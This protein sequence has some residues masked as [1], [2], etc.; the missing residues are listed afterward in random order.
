MAKTNRPPIVTVLGHVDHGKTT[1]LDAIRKTNVQAQE[2]NGITQHISAYQ[3]KI[4][5]Q[6]ITFID[7]PGHQAFVNLR[8][9]GGHLADIAI[10]VVAAD[11][12]VQPQTKESISHIKAANIPYLVAINKIDLPDLDIQ[13]IKTQLAEQEVLV[14]GFGGDIPVVEVSA[15]EQQNLDQL[16]ETLL[17]LSELQEL[18]A[19]SQGILEAIVLESQLDKRRGPLSTLIVKNGTLKKGQRISALADP[20]AQ[21]TIEGKVKSL[22]NWQGKE[23]SQGLPSVPVQ[24]LGFKTPP[25]VGSLV[26]QTES[27][28]E[29]LGLIESQQSNISLG[30]PQADKLNIVLKTDVEGSLEAIANSLPEET[31][32]VFANTGSITESDVLFAE[33]SDA[34]LIGFR[35]QP[36]RSAKKLAQIEE[37][38]IYTFQSIYDLLKKLDQLVKTQS[39]PEEEEVVKGQAKVLKTFDFGD[40]QVI[41]GKITSGEIRLQDNVRAQDS[42]QTAK[43]SSLKKGDQDIKVAQKGDEFGLITKPELDINP[44][45][46]IISYKIKTR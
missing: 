1:L 9:R 18:K 10:L 42:S 40:Y 33:T 3:A 43:V 4:K 25:P 41:G 34:S 8:A 38:P 46:V 13:K 17:A 32:L 35:V 5:D 22:K 30:P 26:T 39:Q 36:N 20:Q 45:D 23:I 14:E 27:T 16:L 15:R 11:D 19:D 24:V 29:F 28:Q 6:P 37:V 44:G 31:Q 21:T 2:T 12:G 7:T